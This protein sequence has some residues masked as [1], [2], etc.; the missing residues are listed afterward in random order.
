MTAGGTITGLSS[1]LHRVPMH[2]PW[3]P[4]M[5]HI[6]VVVTGL[7]TDDGRTGTGFSWAPWVGGRAVHALLES[8]VRDAALGLPA[9]PEIVFDR[10]WWHLHEAGRGGL[11]TTA[12]AAVDLALWDLRAAEHGLTGTLGRRRDAV[13]V[14]GSGVNR[15]YSIEEL[16]A[17]AERWAAQG[18]TAAKIKV[19]LDDLGAD[20]ERVAAVRAVLGPDARLMVDANQLWDLPRALR[21]IEALAPYDLYWVEEPLPAADVGAYAR[22]RASVD[23]PIALGEN[24][25]TTYQ[26]RDLLAVGAC[27][28]VQPNVVR[29]GGVT[30]FLRIV[31]LARTFDVPAYPHL[32][33]DISGQ[34]A[35][36]LPM[37]AMVE[38]VEDASFAD[39]G[40]LAEPY[41]VRIEG[42]LLRPGDHSGHGIRFDPAKLAQTRV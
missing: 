10:L 18:R 2:R 9:H 40:L 12:L 31:E 3:S 21:A 14:Y 11:V 37:P 13:P 19:G 32:L 8:D 27:D 26:F 4:G 41:P 20:V 22:L 7:T 35:C 28:I 29:V 24:T 39:L 5:T 34:L 23:V 16:V 17:Q 1:T 33:P 36:C 6:H 30:P 38:D 25:Y 42:G 15:H